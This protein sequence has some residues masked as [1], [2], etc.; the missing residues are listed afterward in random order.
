MN[1]SCKL[2]GEFILIE[3]PVRDLHFEEYFKEIG[4]AF[5]NNV[6]IRQV[7]LVES[8]IFGLLLQSSFSF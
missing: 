1:E 4:F 8:V 6:E 7:K 3:E 5:C 2:F